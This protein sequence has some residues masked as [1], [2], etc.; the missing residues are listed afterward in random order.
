MRINP[1]KTLGALLAKSAFDKSAFTGI[2]SH[3]D[4]LFKSFQNNDLFNPTSLNQA[5]SN[6][7]QPINSL[8]NLGSLGNGLGNFGNTNIQIPNLNPSK[9]IKINP[10]GLGL[11]LGN[12]NSMPS[13]AMPSPTKPA[14]PT[15]TAPAAKVP[16]PPAPAPTSPPQAAAPQAAPMQAAA[17]PAPVKAQPTSPVPPAA[18]PAPIQVPATPTLVSA[19]AAN[20]GMQSQPAAP[21]KPVGGTMRGKSLADEFQV[22]ATPTL[23]SAPAANPG[24]QSQP[25]APAKPVGGT[26]RGKSL[27]DELKAMRARQDQ[28]VFGTNESPAKANPAQLAGLN[29]QRNP[30]AGN[31]SYPAMSRSIDGGKTFQRPGEQ[32]PASQQFNNY[33]NRESNLAAQ[34]KANRNAAA[35]A[36]GNARI[37]ELETRDPNFFVGTDGPEYRKNLSQGIGI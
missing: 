36:R 20:P 12:N 35:I 25:A 18:A 3:N 2:V 8:S 30:Y 4:N 19:P 16:T 13:M 7:A 17:P 28:G 21:A 24:M 34:Q 22:P 27:A 1:Y 26:M 14:A 37:K 23:V 15:P 31:Y 10:N 33:V 29:T 5:S 11:G 32:N 9:G 6:L